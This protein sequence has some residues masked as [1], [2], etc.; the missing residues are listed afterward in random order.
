VNLA[1]ADAPD[2]C[3]PSAVVEGGVCDVNI[4]K[5]SRGGYHAGFASY[6]YCGLLSSKVALFFVWSYAVKMRG[7]YLRFQAPEVDVEM[8]TC[9]AR[10][11]RAVAR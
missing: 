9:P 8:W 3:P 2:C 4:P 6:L 7:N 10:R 5:C 1:R 11:C